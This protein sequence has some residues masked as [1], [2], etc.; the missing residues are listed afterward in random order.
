MD[1]DSFKIIF[2]VIIGLVYF[3]FQLQKRN[4]KEA[5]PTPST[6]NAPKSL[7]EMLKEFGMQ[8][9]EKQK[10]IEKPQ[11]VY[12]PQKKIDSRS[13]E[14]NIVV[15]N[16]LK[17]IKQIQ[18]DKEQV[19]RNAAIDYEVQGVSYEPEIKKLLKENT[20]TAKKNYYATLMNNPKTVKDAIVIAEIMN[21]KF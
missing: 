9:E 8:V 10:E 16:T 14:G 19:K 18:I 20:G 7:E 1:G 11:P 12:V 5:N 4:K 3:W 13:E 6:E 17:G 15:A 21:R 2:Y